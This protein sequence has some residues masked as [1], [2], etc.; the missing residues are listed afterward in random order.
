MVLTR[1]FLL[2]LA[3]LPPCSTYF[4]SSAGTGLQA[5]DVVALLVAPPPGASAL[6]AAVAAPVFFAAF[7]AANSG[8]D[9]LLSAVA[10]AAL[11]PWAYAYGYNNASSLQG[12]RSASPSPSPPPGAGASAPDVATLPGL[13]LEVG[14]VTRSSDGAFLLFGVF[15][16]PPMTSTALSRGTRHRS[17]ASLFYDDCVWGYIEAPRSCEL[18]YRC[19][20]NYPR[21]Y[22]AVGDADYN[23][24]MCMTEVTG[25]PQL[26]SV[27]A[28]GAD[29]AYQ[30]RNCRGVAAL[31]GQLLVATQYGLGGDDDYVLSIAPGADG[32]PPLGAAIAGAR[33]EPVTHGFF[34]LMKFGAVAARSGGGAS[35]VWVSSLSY[36][37]LQF[38]YGAAA[39]AAAALAPTYARWAPGCAAPAPGVGLGTDGTAR[40]APLPAGC[41]AAPGSDTAVLGLALQEGTLFLSTRHAIF[42]LALALSPGGGADAWRAG[43]APLAAPPGAGWEFRGLAPAP[44][45]PLPVP[46]TPSPSASGSSTL[47]ASPTASLSSGVSASNTGSASW[48]STA[49]PSPSPT[50]TPTDSP[51]PSGTGTPTGTP[52]GTDAPTGTGTPS[53]TATPVPTRSASA[54]IPASPT[55]SVT[56]GASASATGSITGS[57]SATQTPSPTPTE[58][59]SG[60]GT[61]SD[62]G[63]PSGSS[64]LSP[65]ATPAA[66]GAPPLP[67]VWAPPPGAGGWMVLA[68]G[69]LD[70]ATLLSGG[71]PPPA[72][73]LLR[74]A[75]A[76]TWGWGVS[77]EG[78]A[79][80]SVEP[81]PAGAAGGGGGVCG[82]PVPP[83][84]NA[85]V[86]P[87][88]GAAAADADAADV[89]LSALPKACPFPITHGG[90]RAPAGARNGTLLL[91]R[92]AAPPS[93]STALDDAY[94]AS[95]GG[96]LA[97]NSTS[98]DGSVLSVGGVGAGGVTRA[99]YDAALV[100]W[101][102]AGTRA[103]AA[104]APGVALLMTPVFTAVTEGPGAPVNAAAFSSLAAGYWWALCNSSAGLASDGG[105]GRGGGGGSGGGGNLNSGAAPG[106]SASPGGD[107][108]AGAATGGVV[109]ALL[110][111]G[112]AAWYYYYK[113][114]CGC[115]CGGGGGGARG[116]RPQW[117][118]RFSLKQPWAPQRAGEEAAEAP[119][120]WGAPG[121]GVNPL[122]AAAADARRP[123][124]LMRA[125]AV[126]HAANPFA[127][128]ARAVRRSFSMWMARLAAAR[129]AEG[130]PLPGEDA[131]ALP[132]QAQGPSRAATPASGA[133]GLN[134]SPGAPSPPAPTP[135][136]SPPPAYL[137]QGNYRSLDFFR[138][139]AAPPTQARR[140][141]AR[142]GGAGVT[143]LDVADALVD[144][145]PAVEEA[146]GRATAAPAPAAETPGLQL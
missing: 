101:A 59:P 40:V 120:P 127:P 86:A 98:A 80:V 7:R 37:L 93:D 87:A 52:S 47:Y 117:A 9:G 50:G 56:L 51:T 90:A 75:A 81:W 118:A 140:M 102:A 105:D 33:A 8:G 54:S 57:A 138:K 85:G 82:A 113:R 62:T 26:W 20:S 67:P 128:A 142:G 46:P 100:A 122:N 16:Q 77:A 12:S 137:L 32:A 6:E 79:A 109:A 31:G 134:F 131:P 70:G 27:P 61:A 71:P 11:M 21:M 53:P 19:I 49:T 38:S 125:L 96:A 126:A 23:T 60:V 72:A 78:L 123:S 112:A 132:N 146:A 107:G 66:S 116:A 25:L 119:P 22:G 110:I 13:D 58:S 136:R 88:P 45:P 65:S 24:W 91:I 17:L 124:A 121:V 48:S 42:G 74:R 144:V 114:R 29:Q 108:A 135:P 139:A 141:S 34:E 43:G 92:L 89:T 115:G 64:S 35:E 76:A 14:L 145:I 68:A 44:V 1:A 111:L 106:D 99:Q 30:R 18:G 130:T 10:P 94:A 63:S 39:P 83:A 41:T 3:A 97:R 15:N 2:L 129:L 133:R 69:P 73:L 28:T 95:S 143:T 4:T 5:G 36:G 84:D 55:P 104:P 103:W